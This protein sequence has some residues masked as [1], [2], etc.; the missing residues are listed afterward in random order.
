MHPISAAPVGAIRKTSIQHLPVNLFASVMGI[1]GLSLAWQYA[2]Q[3]LGASPLVAQGCGLLALLAYAVM[4]AAYVFKAMRYP[5]AVNAEFEH[6]VLANF[7][8]SIA[9]ATLLASSLLERY[10]TVLHQ[11]L[12]TC[13]VVLTFAI[14]FVI[15]SRL[16]KGGTDGAGAVPAW[17]IPGVATLDIAVTG[18]TMPMAWAHEV[19][20]LAASDGLVLAVLLYGLIVA[21]LVHCAALPPAMTPSL[22]VLVAPFAVGFLAYVNLTGRVDAAA[23]LLFYFALFIFA[24]TAAKVFRRP[25]PFAPAWWAISF[26]LAA[27]ASA[28]LKYAA[29][30]PLTGLS[31]LAAILL[32]FLSITIAVLLARTLV[33]LFNGTLLGG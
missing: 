9:I 1:A 11:L 15:V 24:V 25:A 4:L 32:A 10:S 22:L 12:W 31:V 2:Q 33:V 16:L 17:L 20:L 23:A 30:V 3:T 26:P 21:R 7:F 27:L 5:E 8:G 18:A 19:N 13:G 6:P 28:A 14:S 29:A